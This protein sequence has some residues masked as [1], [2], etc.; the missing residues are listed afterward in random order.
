MSS[1]TEWGK[2]C[3]F[4]FY[5][6][7]FCVVWLTPE[8][9]IIPLIVHINSELLVSG[10]I[11]R[12]LTYNYIFYFFLPSLICLSLNNIKVFILIITIKVLLLKVLYIFTA[13]QTHCIVEVYFRKVQNV[14]WSGRFRLRAA[15]GSQTVHREVLGRC[16]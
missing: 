7:N 15:L 14:L 3:F 10:A 11:Y 13:Y 4:V 8:A 16:G 9:D 12:P 2:Y 6:L 5:I 1:K